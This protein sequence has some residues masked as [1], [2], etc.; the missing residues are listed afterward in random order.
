MP[1]CRIPCCWPPWR[2]FA[3]F[4][5]RW[6]RRISR[7]TPA[8]PTAASW[9]VKF[10]FPSWPSSAAIPT[11]FAPPTSPACVTSRGLASRTCWRIW[12]ARSA[13]WWWSAANPVAAISYCPPV[14][15]WGWLARAWAI[16][17]SAPA[18]PSARSPPC[19]RR[20]SACGCRRPSNAASS[21]LVAPSSPASGCWAPATRATVSSACTPRTAMISC[22]RRTTSCSPPA[23]S[24]AAGWS[25]ACAA[26]AS[27]SLMPTYWASKSAIPGP[28][29]GCSTTIPSW[30]SGSRP[31]RC[32]GCCAAASRLPTSMGQAAYWRTMTP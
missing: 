16:W 23:A 29:A 8:L 32:C 28:V 24:S 12:P 6:R 13:A 20:L 15:R 26:F 30:A 10:A 14:C 17:K 11:S 1:P 4:I 3:I 31:T 19:R 27:P 2:V 22:S 5:R 7:P 21:P 25:R 18:A 9:P